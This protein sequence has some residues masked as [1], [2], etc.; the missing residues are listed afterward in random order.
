MLN[1]RPETA[2]IDLTSAEAQATLTSG[3]QI[4]VVYVKSIS[5]STP[6]LISQF[7]L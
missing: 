3:G 1:V 7:K 4:N 2:K 5:A 6:L